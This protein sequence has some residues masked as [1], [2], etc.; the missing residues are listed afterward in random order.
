MYADLGHTDALHRFVA[1]LGGKS[2]GQR[3][4]GARRVL[5]VALWLAPLVEPADELI[6]QVLT[7]ASRLTGFRDVLFVEQ[8]EQLT[9]FSGLVPPVRCRGPSQAGAGGPTHGALSARRRRA[10]G[11]LISKP[12]TL[13]TSRF[14]EATVQGHWRGSDRNV[15][16]LTFMLRPN[17]RCLPGEGLHAESARMSKWRRTQSR[18][19]A[20]SSRPRASSTSCAIA[21]TSHRQLRSSCLPRERCSCRDSFVSTWT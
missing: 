20:R 18:C 8:I 5:G 7:E 9:H 19:S 21:R 2:F 12:R 11:T 14:Y 16:R 17:A 15:P 3:T 10:H 13:A 1:A 6:R 4:P